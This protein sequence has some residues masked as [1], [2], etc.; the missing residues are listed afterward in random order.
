MKNI[1]SQI[2]RCIQEMPGISDTHYR[3]LNLIQDPDY[4]IHH[5]IKLVESDVFLTTQCLKTVNSAAFSL[6]HKITSIRQA[7]V[8]LGNQMLVRLALTQAFKSLFT[9][10][11]KGYQSD[12]RD[13]WKHSLQTAMGARIIANKEHVNIA[14][15]LVYTAGLLH[16]IGKAIISEYLEIF[17][18]ELL[19]SL[20]SPNRGDFLSIEN[21]FLGTNH[22]KVGEAMAQKWNLPEPLQAVIRHHHRPSGASGPHVDLVTVVHVADLLSMMSGYGTGLDALAY[23]MDSSTPSQMKLDRNIIQ[24]LKYEMYLEFVN[25][26]NKFNFFMGEEN[27]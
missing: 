25:I 18:K 19:K 26:K 23:R 10:S 7:I 1:L 20:A 5:L 21:N 3:I 9:T 22:C 14:P 27:G 4:S 11:L 13:F 6:R 8:L 16:D 15:D 17:H 2:T 12:F 24:N